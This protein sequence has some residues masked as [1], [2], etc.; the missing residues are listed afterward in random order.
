MLV[1]FAVCV[2][3]VGCSGRN[4]PSDDDGEESDTTVRVDSGSPEDTSSA[5]IEED[6]GTCDCEIDGE[7][8]ADGERHPERTCKV[9]D[10]DSSTTD[11]TD[12][13]EGESCDDG[14]SCTTNDQCATLG[15]CQGERSSTACVIEG[16]CYEEGDAKPGEAC[17][18]C[19]PDENGLGWTNIGV[20][21][22]CD[23]GLSCTS[24]TTCN[25]DGECVGDIDSGTCA[26]DEG[27][28]S[29]GETNPENPCLVC[30]VSNES[31]S[32]SF[33]SSGTACDDGLTCTTSGT[34]NETG[35]CVTDVESG[36][37]VVSNDGDSC[38]S[39]GDTHPNS[40]CLVCDP[41]EDTRG[42]SDSDE[43]SCQ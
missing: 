26:T 11:W 35:S 6:A 27:C 40:D 10:P 13:P 3:N 38:V 16:T 7:C 20:G 25:A 39:E 43:P 36:Y 33:V 19:Q 30:D 28:Y 21:E 37:C 17:K 15:L 32:W 14:L 18:V 31:D 1:I 12:R 8:Y 24:S 9:C 42:W 22:S 2:Q 4:D 41:S 5:D 34:C 29:D 23:D